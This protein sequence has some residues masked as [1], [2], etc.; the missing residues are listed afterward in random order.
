MLL[1]APTQR[2]SVRA[3]KRENTTHRDSIISNYRERKRESVCERE[4]AHHTVMLLL[5]PTERE[6]VCVRERER[7]STP[8]RDAIISMYRGR[9]RERERE[10]D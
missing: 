6:C 10:R 5:A 2:E 7:E 9:E 1:S 4:R 8:H 3:C